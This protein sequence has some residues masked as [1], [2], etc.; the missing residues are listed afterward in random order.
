MQSTGVATLTAP[1][2]CDDSTC[3]E[4]TSHQVTCRCSCGGEGHALG[5]QV[6]S[7]VAGARFQARSVGGFTPS[8]LGAISDD[9][10]W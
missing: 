6:A 7:V 2:I 10:P 9:Q 3:R 8:M 1:L 4:A 5:R